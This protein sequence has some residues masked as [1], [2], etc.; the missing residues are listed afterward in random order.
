M[1]VSAK[2]IRRYTLAYQNALHVLVAIALDRFPTQGKLRDSRVVVLRGR[3][4][5]YL[6]S[7]NSDSLQVQIDGESLT[8][9]M[10]SRRLTLADDL[11]GNSIG[12][13]LEGAYDDLELEGS[14]ILDIGCNVG[15][16]SLYFYLKGA[17]KVIG[18]DPFPAVCAR[19]EDNVRLSGAEGFVMIVNAACLGVSGIARVDANSTSSLGALV[20]M[21]SSGGIHV[22]SVT[23]TQLLDRFGVAR[24][25]MKVDC[26]GC[27]FVFLPRMSTQE[28]KRLDRIV[29]EYHASPTSLVSK[30]R[31]CGFSTRLR[32]A[33][34]LA[35]R[36]RGLL[37]AVQTGR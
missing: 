21:K 14:T 5:A 22:P 28:L 13:I 32:G 31:Q 19:A 33:S 8:I 27:E 15:D 4:E 30:L 3:L 1:R 24:A 10:G 17:S 35:R 11:S 23:P 2:A 20:D 9:T 29:L 34:L 26:E 16:S 25:Q 7:F 6:Y 36:K 18:V 12:E 37:I